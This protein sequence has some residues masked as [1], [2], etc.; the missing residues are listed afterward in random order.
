MSGV[1]RRAKG[2]VQLSSC[3]TH[4]GTGRLSNRLPLALTQCRQCQRW[5]PPDQIT[6]NKKVQTDGQTS[7]S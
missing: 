2:R 1:T 3:S 5:F 4:T 7:A 6:L